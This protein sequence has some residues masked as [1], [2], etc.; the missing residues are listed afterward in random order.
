MVQR[1]VSSAQAWSIA[2]GPFHETDCVVYGT[3]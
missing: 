3:L 2:D 1:T